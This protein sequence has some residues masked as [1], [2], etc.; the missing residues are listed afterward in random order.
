MSKM[1][2]KKISAV[3]RPAWDYKKLNVNMFQLFIDWKARES[4]KQLVSKELKD[5]NRN[6]NEL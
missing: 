6:V 4:T 2:S 3:T 1:E 5:S